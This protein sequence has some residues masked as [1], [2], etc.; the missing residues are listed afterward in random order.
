MENC[1]II[2]FDKEDKIL[3]ITA[4]KKDFPGYSELSSNLKDIY[5]LSFEEANDVILLHELKEI[6]KQELIKKEMG[7]DEFKKV[8]AKFPNAKILD[9]EEIERKDNND[10]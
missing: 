7:S 3:K 2:L 5:K 1:E 8:L 6:R 4:N 9:I 10:G